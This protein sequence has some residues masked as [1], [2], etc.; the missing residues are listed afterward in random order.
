MK[1]IGLTG[2]IGSGKSTVARFLQELGAVII[3]ADKVG[4]ELLESDAMLRQ[5]LIDAFGE[6]VIGTGG[7]ISRP[8]LAKHAFKN[9][10]SVEKLNKIMHPVMLHH[11]KQ[12]IDKYRDQKIPVVILDAP[13]IIEAGWDN[14]VEQVWAV[15]APAE[16]VL[17]RL[18]NRGLSKE[19]ALARIEHQL[20]PEEKEKRADAVIINDSTLDN[21]KKKVLLLWE[22]LCSGKKPPPGKG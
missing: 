14:L 16:T 18:E 7:R 12:L 5:L 19:Q 15:T 6:K 13:L 2:G 1:I 11:V 8:E 22:E 21:L 9:A 17:R 20:P 10:H 3:D 4:H